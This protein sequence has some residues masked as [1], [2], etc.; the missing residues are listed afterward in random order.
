[1]IGSVYLGKFIVGILLGRWKLNLKEAYFPSSFL[2]TLLRMQIWK[3][4]C[5]PF[6][7][8]RMALFLLSM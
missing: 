6:I 3:G 7:G 8:R 1:M 5:C 2:T 4:T